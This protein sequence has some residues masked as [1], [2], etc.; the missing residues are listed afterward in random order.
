MFQCGVVMD[1]FL[2]REIDVGS[3]PSAVYAVGNSRGI[4]HEGALGNA[5]AVPARVRATLDTIYD[6]ASLTKPLVTTP[7]VLKTV[8]NLD[9]RFQG[10]TFRE[11]LTHTSGLRAW[12]PLYA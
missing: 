6:C 2:R 5:V 3:F 4:T 9:E 11:L 1:S 12:L 10:Y 7:L 8:K